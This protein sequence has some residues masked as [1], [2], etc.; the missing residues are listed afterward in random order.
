MNDEVAVYGAGAYGRIFAR[1]LEARGRR[2]ML[3]IDQYALER[4]RH[5]LPVLRAAEVEDRTMTVYMSAIG[6]QSGQCYTQKK[7]APFVP[8]AAMRKNA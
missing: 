3:F 2:V 1:A 8:R 7:S 5:G 6:H 4:Q